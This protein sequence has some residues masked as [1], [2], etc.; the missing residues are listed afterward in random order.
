MGKWRKKRAFW[1][2]TIQN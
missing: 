2:E 1:R